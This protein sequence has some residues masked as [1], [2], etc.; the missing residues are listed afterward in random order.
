MHAIARTGGDTVALTFDRDGRVHYGAL[1]D[2]NQDTRSR[3]PALAP[4]PRRD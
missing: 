1:T 4:R 3:Y 2:L